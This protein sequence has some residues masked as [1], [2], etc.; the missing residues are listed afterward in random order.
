MTLPFQVPVNAD[1]ETAAI[2]MTADLLVRTITCGKGY[3]S[4]YAEK[5]EKIGPGL[6]KSLQ[7]ALVELY[8]AS[9]KLLALALEECEKRTARRLV[10]AFLNPQKSQGQV[11]NVHDCHSNLRQ[12]AQ[13]CQTK[14]VGDIDKSMTEF[15]DKFA[16]LNLSVESHF[17]ELFEKIEE[18]RRT[19]ILDWISKAKPFDRHSTI[20]ATR[21]PETCG[22]LLQSKEFIDWKHTFAPAVLWLQGSR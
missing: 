18:W 11:S 8:V 19:Q 3:E 9:L 2:L 21:A 22:W 10:E 5:F 7:S 20:K 16:D 12:V 4:A 13:S 1:A 6:W 15:L 17:G 14:V